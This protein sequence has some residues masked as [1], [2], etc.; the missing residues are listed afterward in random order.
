MNI[1][2]IIQL[3]FTHNWK[4]LTV[5]VMGKIVL[6]DFQLL[7]YKGNDEWAIGCRAIMK[8]TWE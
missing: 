4:G 8:V 1:F 5:F 3:R 2:Q 7:G 6:I